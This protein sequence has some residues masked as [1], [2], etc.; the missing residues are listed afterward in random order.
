MRKTLFV[1]IILAFSLNTY[2]QSIFK[3]VGSE[4]NIVQRNCVDKNDVIKSYSIVLAADSPGI[5]R[6]YPFF[7]NL[8]IDSMRAIAELLT[9]QGDTRICTLPVVGHNMF[10][11]Q[12]YMGK[13]ENYSIQ[14]EA[15]FLINQLV[16]ERP[17]N[18]SDYPVLVDKA[19]G[20][21]A[22]ISG[23]IIDR[24]FEAYRNWY[25]LISKV[26]LEKIRANNIYPLDGTNLKWH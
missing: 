12:L 23:D 8:V 7:K 21:E 14:V 16:L 26:G 5:F 13:L 2:A 19:S 4:G 24:A 10:S 25:A 3:V 6:S 9:F 1:L 15:L 20:K 18:Y 11:S 22:T 17:F